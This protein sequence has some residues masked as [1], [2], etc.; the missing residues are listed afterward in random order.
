M[1]YSVMPDILLLELERCVADLFVT[2]C[3][4]EQPILI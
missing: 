4:L 2:E 1:V 3:V